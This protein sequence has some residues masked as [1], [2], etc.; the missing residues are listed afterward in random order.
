MMTAH[1]SMQQG[2][3]AIQAGNRAE[4]ERLLRYAVKDNA[5]KGRLRATAF[6][7][8]GEVVTNRE[9]KIRFFNEALAVDPANDYAEER[10]ADLLRPPASK[11][12]S[13]PPK[14][15]D[16]LPGQKETP[17]PPPTL[18]GEAQALVAPPPPAPVYTPPG[19]Q[20][21]VFA[22]TS[23]MPVPQ[24][25]AAADYYVVGIL[26]GPNGRG[27]GFFLTLDGMVVTTRFV[28]GARETVTVEF[29]RGNRQIAQVLRSFPD[30]DVALLKTDQSVRQLLTPAPA[31]NIADNT[32]ITIL[33]HNQDNA[34]GR[35]R[36]TGR[37][38]APHL[39]P[40]DITRLPDAGG[41][42]VLNDRQML[43][44]MITRNISSTSAYVYGVHLAAVQR[45][46][47]IYNYELRSVQNREYCSAC[48]YASAAATVGGFYCESCGTVMPHAQNQTRAQTPSMASLYDDNTYLACTQCGARAG[49]YN[50]L[51]LR[52]G[53][54][55]DPAQVR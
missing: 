11:P 37:A 23:T 15:P 54:A 43:V 47:D 52:C 44:G 8:L 9:E 25:P 13:Q 28:V 31:G 2:I 42:P 48:G 3:E 49:F 35:R 36:E 14:P 7:W 32:P 27:S 17:P 45:C 51:C 33:C 38:L 19:T 50:G 34:L 4:G 20:R 16:T 40:T 22:Q 24:Q 10:L 39:F 46:L 55:G 53:R 12:Q 18:P 5:L 30:V 21:P 6:N 29:E 41:G 26:D 1:Q